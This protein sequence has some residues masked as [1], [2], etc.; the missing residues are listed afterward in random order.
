MV[1]QQTM[2]GKEYG[3][4]KKKTKGEEF[5]E[6]MDKI[7]PWD[8]WVGVIRPYYPT[9]KHC[10]PRIDLELILQMYLLQCWIVRLRARD[11]HIRQL[12]YAEI[13]RNRFSA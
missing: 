2:S 3:Y 10:C 9:G 5:L 1:K 13:Y 4:R 7:I 11:H 8:E 12:C 6:I